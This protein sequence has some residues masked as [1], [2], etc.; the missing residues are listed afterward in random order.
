MKQA[1][2]LAGLLIM[3]AFAREGMAAE[4]SYTLEFTQTE[5]EWLD[6]KRTLRFSEV[7]WKPLSDVDGFP[8]YQGII[9]EYL[10]LVSDATGIKMAF[11]KSDTWHDVIEKFKA[12]K[13]DLIPALSIR[14]DIGADVVF[15]QPYLT[16]P[17]VIATRPAID[18]IGYTNELNK[19]IVG[20]GRNYTSYYF[21][22]NNYPKI[23]LIQTDD[24][25]QG[26]KM[27]EGGEIDAFVGHL[28][29]I[30]HT[31]NNTTLNV[32]IAGKTEYDFEHRMGF[33]KNDEIAAGIFN[34]VFSQIPDQ[35]HNLIYNK[36]IE[37]GDKRI[38]YALIWKVAVILAVFFSGVGAVIIYRYYLLNQ[39]NQKL[40]TMANTDALTQCA[41]RKK[42]NE[43]L[44]LAEY[45][46][47]RYHIPFS[48]ILIDLD[49]FKHVNDS[50]GHAVG[51][52][53]LKDLS[54]ILKNNVRITDT[55]GRW[56]GEEFLIVCGNTNIYGAKETAE[57]LRKLIHSHHFP[58]IEKMTASFGISQCGEEELIKD[59]FVRIDAALYRAK[60]KGKNR[61]EI[62]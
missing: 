49:N 12:D 29:V 32:K 42:I 18:F 60:E 58:E 10:K 8:V 14:D 43:D 62:S 3:I 37:M 38:N 22:K 52:K 57:K 16:F 28:A 48:L 4:D 5:R 9:A 40:I 45:N 41:N 11:Y 2:V 61:I 34:K 15:T 25:P 56:G 59:F 55:V 35:Q 24:V 21:L 31:I 27:L 30:L 36:W 6:Q 53:V 46:W 44:K 19:K 26:L 51:D 50:F 20:V 39:L 54:L 47:H 33:H 1:V 7:N 13:I 17:L 23:T